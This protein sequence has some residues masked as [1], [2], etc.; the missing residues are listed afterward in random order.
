MNEWMDEIIEGNG[1]NFPGWESKVPTYL[2]TYLPTCVPCER[3]PFDSST[4]HVPKKSLGILWLL[5]STSVS[6]PT[7]TARKSWVEQV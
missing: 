6:A 3:E 2:P 1:Q 4:W 5:S 7:T